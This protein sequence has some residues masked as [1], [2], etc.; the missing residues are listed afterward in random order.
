[1]LTRALRPQI[2]AASDRRRHTHAPDLR[3]GH[4]AR[5]R[6]KPIMLTAACWRPRS[7]KEALV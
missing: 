6:R 4:A 1:M 3:S 5:G 2:S 7:G